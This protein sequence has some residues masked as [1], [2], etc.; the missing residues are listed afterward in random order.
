[1]RIVKN[2]LEMI[3]RSRRLS[4][5]VLEKVVAGKQVKQTLEDRRRH[6]VSCS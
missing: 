5:K 4:N 3:T 1:M 6:S 2:D